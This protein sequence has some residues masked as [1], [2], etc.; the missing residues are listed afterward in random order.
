MNACRPLGFLLVG[1]SLVGCASIARQREEIAKELHQIFAQ[2]TEQQQPTGYAAVSRCAEGPVRRAYESRA[3]PY[4][5]LVDLY[6]S[7]WTSLAQK[8]D[9][10]Q[11]APEEAQLQLSEQLFRLTGE[12]L[13]RD[14]QYENYRL[15]LM[16][17]RPILPPRR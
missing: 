6:L 14:G 9:G 11:L 5:D 1:L 4:M 13:K 12:A 16:E 3:Y 7:H 10:G 2:C 17:L 15:L 8:V